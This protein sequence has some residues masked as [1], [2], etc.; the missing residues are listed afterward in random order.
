MNCLKT[1][2]VAIIETTKEDKK[3][4]AFVKPGFNFSDFSKVLI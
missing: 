3:I 2:I 4:K 1:I